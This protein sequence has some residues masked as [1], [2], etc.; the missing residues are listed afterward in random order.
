MTAFIKLPGVSFSLL[1]HGYGVNKT[2]FQLDPLPST[3]APEKGKKKTKNS[4][5]ANSPASIHDSSM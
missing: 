5:P 3:S 4:G 2:H 1:Q